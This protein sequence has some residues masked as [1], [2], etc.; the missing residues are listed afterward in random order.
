MFRSGKGFG[1]GLSSLS[2]TQSVSFRHS[3]NNIE[4]GP[5]PGSGSGAPEPLD[6]S[7]AYTLDTM[8]GGKSRDFS[9]PMYDAVQ[10]GA[11]NPDAPTIGN[12]S[13][14]FTLYFSKS[15]KNKKNIF[16]LS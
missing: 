8:N 6:A 14:R 4:F 9:N 10:A 13:G 3:G 2:P 1:S 16:Q 11:N 12:G 15:F 7:T 5:N